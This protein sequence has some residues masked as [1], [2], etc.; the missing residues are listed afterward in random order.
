VQLGRDEDTM[1]TMRAG[2]SKD[3]PFLEAML[4]EAF[5]WNEGAHRP[6]LIEVRR[7][8]EFSIQLADWGRAGDVALVAEH[9][10]RPVGAAWFRLWTAD[11][12]SYGFVD[13]ETP[14]LGIGVEP[15]LRSRGIG[16][17]LLQA[18]LET[19]DAHGYLGLSL[20]VDP[21]NLARGLYES[22]GFA[23]VGEVETSWTMWRK[24]GV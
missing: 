24:R 13:D 23:K 19:A 16:R 8:P 21:A 15:G 17:A 14:E 20:S 7:R 10:D 5:F 1:V 12:H 11:A 4:Y 9:G 22:E 2:T 6:P 18:L 3:L